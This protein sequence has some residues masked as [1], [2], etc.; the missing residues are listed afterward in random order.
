[1]LLTPLNSQALQEVL[2]NGTS[3]LFTQLMA[4]WS[5]DAVAQAA[6]LR[7][8]PGDSYFDQVLA[9]AAPPPPHADRPPLGLPLGSAIGAAFLL[10]VTATLCV[11]IHRQG[12]QKRQQQVGACVGMLSSPL[13]L[14]IG[15]ASM[16]LCNNLI[17]NLDVCCF[18]DHLRLEKRCYHDCCCL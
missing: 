15:H 6:D 2:G 1:M 4:N 13:A 5:V 11:Y 8:F 7:P 18:L 12:K 14:Y 17:T 10:A 9:Y 3:S 16:D